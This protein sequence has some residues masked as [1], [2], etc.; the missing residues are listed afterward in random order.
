MVSD[1]LSDKDLTSFGTRIEEVLKESLSRSRIPFHHVEYHPTNG[2]NG[3][4]E[5]VAFFCNDL[6]EIEALI[7]RQFV[8]DMDQS[9][10]LADRAQGEESLPGTYLANVDPLRAK[11]PE[12]QPYSNESILILVSSLFQGALFSILGFFSGEKLPPDSELDQRIQTFSVMAKDLDEGFAALYERHLRGKDYGNQPPRPAET[13][14]PMPESAAKDFDEKV[15]GRDLPKAEVT[16][17]ENILDVASVRL[18]LGAGTKIVRMWT[19][20]ASESGLTILSPEEATDVAEQEESLARLF[21]FLARHDITRYED[22]DGFLTE[23]LGSWE[24][25]YEALEFARS[26]KAFD[27]HEICLYDLALMLLQAAEAHR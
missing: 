10:T 6:P 17:E 13:S 7:Q 27:R 11:L 12:W 2:G 9:V 20:V 5:V 19:S 25:I 24:K 22:M 3:A 21:S 23:R 26:G 4:V 18:Y 8:V 1:R 15:S 14:T 16:Q